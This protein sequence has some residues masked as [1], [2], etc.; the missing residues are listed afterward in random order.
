M[1]S[2]CARHQ[3]CRRARTD[4]RDTIFRI[5]SLS[6]P[7]VSGGGAWCSIDAGRLAIDEPDRAVGC[8]S[9]PTAGV[10]RTC[11]RALDDTVPADRPDHRARPAR[12]RR[13]GSAGTS[14][15]HV[16]RPSMQALDE[17]D[18]ATTPPHPAGWRPIDE[19][20]RGLHDLPLHHQPGERWMYHTSYDVLGALVARI[21]RPARS[22]P[23]STRRSSDRSAWSTPRSG[24]RRTSGAGSA[25]ASAQQPTDGRAVY[26]PTDGKWA[27][28][29]HRSSRAAAASCRRVADYFAFVDMLRRR[30]QRRPVGR[31]DRGDDHQPPHAARRSPRPGPEPGDDVGL[32][33][34][35][36]ASRSAPS[37][38][39]CADRHVRLGRRPRLDR[40]RTDPTA[41]VVAIL[42]TNQAF[43]TPEPL[44]IARSF[45]SVFAA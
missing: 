21:G 14:T 22:A 28:A 1:R 15:S 17:R 2:G 39:A 31:R 26:D 38:Q 9:S 44:P 10:L 24:C 42:L 32:G 16:R 12:R 25:P 20:L 4:H 6:K 30:R 40:W 5:S 7:I 13:W 43:L 29:T 23:S 35:H 33:L 27:G 3:R 41:D 11:G 34:R 37:R 8:R 45:R 18:L 19:W 36:R